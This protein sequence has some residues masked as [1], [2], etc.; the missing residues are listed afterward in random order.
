MNDAGMGRHGSR[1]WFDFVSYL[2][3]HE[4]MPCRIIIEAVLQEVFCEGRGRKTMMIG[5]MR[6]YCGWNV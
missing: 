1:Y 4:Y 2:L 6:G 5:V 3:V